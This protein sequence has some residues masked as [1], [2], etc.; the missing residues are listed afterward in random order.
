MKCFHNHEG[1]YCIRLFFKPFA[2]VNLTSF[3]IYLCF[4]KLSGPSVDRTEP[5]YLQ[6][7]VYQ[8]QIFSLEGYRMASSSILTLCLPCQNS[9]LM[10]L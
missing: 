5:L 4:E 8:L 10:S 2:T 1:S 3:S 9:V 7:Q 6:Q